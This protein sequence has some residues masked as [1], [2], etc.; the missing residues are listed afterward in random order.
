[1]RNIIAILLIAG[2]VTL[3]AT[4]PASAQDTDPVSVLKSGAS[5]SEKMEAC[6]ILSVKGTTEAIPALAPLLLD[7]KLSHMARY[8]LEP[9]PY[10]EVDAVLRD[11]LG[12][13]SGLLKV[14]IIS[15]LAA[16]DDEEAVAELA[17]LLSDSD[18]EV[19]QASAK[20]LG[21]I[22]TPDGAQAL[23]DALSQGGISPNL[24][25]AICN[26]LL[27]CAEQFAADGQ[28]DGAVAI[29]DGLRNL[30]DTP[31]QVQTAAL[32]GAVLARSVEEGLP[33]LVE[34][35]RGEDELLFRSALRIARES[36]GTSAVS[37][38]LADVLPALPDARKI[39]LLGVFGEPDGASAGP[40]ALSE[41][42]AGTTEVRVAALHA[43][44]RMGYEPALEL[45][46]ELAW[47]DD[48]EL[49]SAARDSL[50]YFPGNKGDAALEAML[51]DE[52]PEARRVAVELIGQGAMEEPIGP[53]MNA[54]RLDSD[55]GVR[56]AALTALQS[57]AGMEELPL[58]L[59][60]LLQEHS[61]EE[62]K[63]I[64]SV[65]AAISERQKRM[66]GGIVIQSAIYGDLPDGPSADVLDQVQRI[67]DSGATSV[68]ASNG[69]FGDPAPNR[70]KQLRIDYTEN[71]T[72]VSKKVREGGTLKLTAVSAPAE[73]VDAFCAALEKA[74]GDAKLGIIRLLGATA[75]PKAFETVQA[76]A[77]SE[78]ANVKDAALRTL[79]EWPTAL[80]LPVVLDLVNTSSDPSL[81][82]SALRG[83]VRL[84]GQGGTDTEKLLTTYSMLMSQADTSDEKK[85]VLSGLAQVSDSK[86]LKMAFAQFADE[87]VKVEAIQA[88]INIARNL[89]SSAREDGAFF[90]G[91]DLI[92]WQGNTSYW[93][94]EDGAIVGHSDAEIPNNEFLWSNTPVSDFYLALDVRLDPN[95]ANA[96]IQFR[97]T[98]MDDKGQAQGYQADVGQSYWGR[99]YHEHGR[100]MLDPTDAA[101]QAVKPGEWNRY[102]ILA[103]GPAI[104][105]AINGTL[106]VAY[107]DLHQDAEASGQI[108]LQIHS[109]PPQTVSYRIVQ[110]VHNP[111]VELGDLKLDD[112]IIKLKV[113]NP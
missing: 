23:N 14:G 69:N 5:V 112:L 19:A 79:C 47:S 84:L 85:I 92:G 72:P 3:A 75:S 20:A 97:S 99:L 80:A 102:E 50:S 35:L 30:P 6:R 62:M 95:T 98:K 78:D 28:R 58:L 17:K 93:H 4:V 96:G 76:A 8:A 101:E 37:A 32:R 77:A 57:I 24:S 91:T 25:L 113:S 39:Q 18:A 74:E 52:R 22:A 29:Y 108:A 2:A 103:V 16:R 34:A 110:L 65:V 111:K 27:G 40:A 60:S 15:S 104:W 7:E 21:D 56:L 48:G 53:L 73:V 36:G 64:E 100:G 38:A 87:S 33:L 26:G 107:L 63:T 86:A 105:T 61:E 43:V 59:D 44:T 1:M 66:P 9:M 81:K 31:S 83:T 45:I 51:E 41:A 88:A 46:E 67:V 109:G 82:L 71:G 49:A 11:A 94:V 89:G 55:E 12:K 90:S 70:V 42:Q 68:D 10:P 13:T 106:G 54:A